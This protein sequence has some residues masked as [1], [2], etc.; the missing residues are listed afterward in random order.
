MV[1]IMVRIMV[2][3]MARIMVATP[4]WSGMLCET[5][6]EEEGGGVVAVTC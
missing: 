5:Y 1:A 3:I 2:R 6:K 4:W